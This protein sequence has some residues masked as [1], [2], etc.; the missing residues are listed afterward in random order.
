[1]INV[2]HRALPCDA[3]HE[4]RRQKS[5]PS[6]STE[7]T[8]RLVVFLL[9]SEEYALA[10]EAVQEI[11]RYSEPRAVASDI[12]GIE[13][14]ISLRGKIIPVCDLAGRLGLAQTRSQEAKIIIVET[15]SGAA[16][17][18]VE[19]VK[20]VLAIDEHS[21]E[22]TLATSGELVEAIA[23]IGDRLVVVLDCE[24]IFAELAVAA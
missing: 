20:E 16:G 6:M 1:M 3:D 12:P 18:I 5:E 7:N 11:I 23:R 24:R 14:V 22:T 9:G 4:A 19:E 15:A 17:V 13:G 8:H 2:D 21:L 10:I